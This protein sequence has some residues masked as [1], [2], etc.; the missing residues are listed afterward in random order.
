MKDPRVANKPLAVLRAGAQPFESADDDD[1]VISWIG[2][3]PIVLLGES[4]HGTHDFYEARARLTQKLIEQKGFAAVAIEGDWPDAYQVNRYVLGG[5]EP[6]A[7]SALSG[8]RRFPSWMWRNTVVADFVEWLREHN[9]ATPRPEWRTGFYGLDL[10]SLHTSIRA[11]VDYLD[12]RDPDAARAA[13]MSYA[14]FD[15]FGHD[16]D[17]YAWAAGRLGVE[18]CE[19]EV[20]RELVALHQRQMELVRRNGPAASEEFFSAEQN[21]RLAYNAEHYYRTM[22]GGRIAAWNI[23]DEHM[24]EILS[25]LLEHM[26]SR[27][28]APKV[29]VWAHNSHVGDARATEMGEQGGRNLGQLLRERYGPRVKTIGFTTYT[30][31]V[32]A[33]SDWN[34]RAACKHINPALPDSYEELFHEMDRPRFFLPILPDSELHDALSSRRL[35]RGIGVVY[36][37][38]NE[39]QSHYFHARLASQF[40]AIIHLDETR[41]LS[42]LEF[43]QP[44]AV[45]EPAETFP[46]GT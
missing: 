44:P 22:F 2:D 41:A 25:E 17:S 6:D 12:Q 24:A 9:K 27:N 36:R 4:S 45:G 46:E 3:A 34:G 32:I 11:V 18:T 10:Y 37:P 20:T 28:Q 43:A 29:V 8:F 16:A 26:Q 35:E 33:A 30:G 19:A 39:R 42:P 13:R 40:D 5:N 21:A 23:R 14:C 31:T 7:A 38:A 15:H 1:R